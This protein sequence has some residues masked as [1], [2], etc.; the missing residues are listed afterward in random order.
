M[1]KNTAPTHLV[2]TVEEGKDGKNYYTKLGIA[3]AHKT[4]KGMNVQLTAF[5]IDGRI[6]IFARDE[7]PEG[8][9]QTGAAE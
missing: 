7:K 2:Y 8:T 1:S 3:W 9:D 6:T 5:P 4:G